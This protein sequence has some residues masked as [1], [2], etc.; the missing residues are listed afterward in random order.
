MKK[1]VWCTD[2]H[3]DFLER[4]GGR[5]RV[6]DEFI[7]PLSKVE[8]DGFFIS[9]DISLTEHLIDHLDLFDNLVNNPVYF[10]LGNHDFYGGSFEGVRRAVRDLCAKSKNLRYLTDAGHV[11]LTEKVA[12]VGEDG[13]YDALHGDFQRSGY[14]MT[15]WFRI[16]DYLNAGAMGHGSFGDRPNMGTVVSLSRKFASESALRVQSSLREA[17]KTHR[18]VI[19]LTHV[20]PWPQVHKTGGKTSAPTSHPW[21]T[22]KMMGDVISEVANENP[23]VKFEVFCGHTHGKVS[24]N[25]S[26]NVTC[27]VGGATYD[28]PSI[29]GT[30][31]LE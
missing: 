22:S 1:F 6:L 8:C 9:G 23:D 10:V 12:L 24:A 25:I 27:H 28:E 18:T 7:V 13:W 30:L 16:H 31:V 15:D 5:V 3:L 19:V 26:H 20:P 21:Y 29:S 4:T 14:V 11:S 2:I 17:A